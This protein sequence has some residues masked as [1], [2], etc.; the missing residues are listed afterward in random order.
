[1]PARIVVVGLGPGGPDLV[2]A[3]TLARIASAERCLLRT[4]RHPAASVVPGAATFDHVYER[5]AT[6][7]DVYRAIVDELVAAGVDA[8]HGELVYAVPGSPVVAERTVEL[9][10]AEAEHRDDLE[11]E[12]V[13]GAVV[14]RPGLGPARASIPSPGRC[15]WSTASASRSRR[16]ASGAR[17]WWPSAT[18]CT[19]CPT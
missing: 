7:D 1:M 13:P 18:R 14:P 3:G 16:P 12:I 5:A 8:G 17:C 4:T 19:C 2:T 6:L 10:L 11:V 15:G 9:L